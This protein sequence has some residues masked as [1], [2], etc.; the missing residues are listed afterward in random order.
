MGKKKELKKLNE[1][2]KKYASNKL[3]SKNKIAAI[4]HLQKKKKELKNE[5][6][7]TDS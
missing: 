7:T 6:N 5:I 2:I 4:K 3:K 1:Q